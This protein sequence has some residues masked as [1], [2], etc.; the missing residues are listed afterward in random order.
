M[1]NW[2]AE[3]T[4]KQDMAIAS[5][6]ARVDN[7][8]YIVEELK[9]IADDPGMEMLKLVHSIFEDWPMSVFRGGEVHRS[10]YLRG[11]D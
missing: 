11:G 3:R 9:A 2:L 4:R 1:N 5:L 10:N 8:E 7:L 6:L